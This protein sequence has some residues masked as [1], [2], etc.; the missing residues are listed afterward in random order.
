MIKTS[1]C[2]QLGILQFLNS[3]QKKMFNIMTTQFSKL[4]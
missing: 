4:F 2:G 1:Y 3:I